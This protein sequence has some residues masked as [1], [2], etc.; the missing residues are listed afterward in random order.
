VRTASGTDFTVEA[1]ELQRHEYKFHLVPTLWNQYRGPSDLDWTCVRFDRA[2]LN[3]VPDTP[4]V[5][6]FCVS[7]SIGGNICGSY[8]LY[9]GKTGRG[10]RTRCRE[11]LSRAE[12]GRERPKLDRM[13]RPFY[14]TRY[15]RFCFA[16]LPNRDIDRIEDSL[17]EATV[18][19]GC[20]VLPASVRAAVAALR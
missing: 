1:D 6:A 11:Y 16:L 20:T 12:A 18:P 10:L 13:L 19:P 8:L 5:Y 9:V 3:A 14:G 17:Q 4:G 2:T 15:L 7:P